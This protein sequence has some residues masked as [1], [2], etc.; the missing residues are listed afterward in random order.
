MD[1][2]EGW[3]PKADEIRTSRG[4]VNIFIGVYANLCWEVPYVQNAWILNLIYV[5]SRWKNKAML[6][7]RIDK[8]IEKRLDRLARKTGRT[9]TF[10]AREAFPQR[11]FN[12]SSMVGLV[13]TMAGRQFDFI[14]S[15]DG[16]EG[17]YSR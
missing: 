8:E 9:K 12:W 14:M 1:L 15:A 11:T 5:Y 6:A 16:T 3:G 17:H 13:P 2:S 4:I 7:I 10:Y